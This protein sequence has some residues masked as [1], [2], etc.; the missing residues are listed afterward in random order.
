MAQHLTADRRRKIDKLYLSGVKPTEIARKMGMKP[1]SLRQYLYREGLTK[2]RNE[3]EEVKQRTVREVLES[4][5]QKSVAD[6]EGVMELLAEGV[7]IDA[8]KLRNG[9]ELATD[10][11]GASSLMR[12][13]GLLLDRALK[14]YGVESGEANAPVKA[15]LSLFFLACPAVRIEKRVGPESDESNKPGK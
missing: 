14:T 2:R 4:V 1:A 10:A 11:A 12:A 9:W 8:K 15:N 3:I 7:K 6:F 13:K 5:R